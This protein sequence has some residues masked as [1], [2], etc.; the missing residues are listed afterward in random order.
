MRSRAFSRTA[1]RYGIGRFLLKLMLC[2][3]VFLS[4]F[5]LLFGR[6]VRR[7]VVMQGYILAAESLSRSVVTVMEESGLSYS[8][9]CRITYDESGRISSMVYDAVTLNHLISMLELRATESL[10]GKQNT[11]SLPLGTLMGSAL[12]SGRGPSISLHTAALGYVQAESRSDFSS[13]GL[14][15]TRHRIVVTLTAHVNVYVP[16]YAKDFVVTREFF[17]A[18][19]ILVGEVPNMILNG[20]SA[21]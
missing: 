16:F 8:D 18:E 1:K 17:I 9:L 14:N 6:A 5:E 15:Q 2:I 19:T 13:A 20:T 3:F 21:F 10:S 12:L 11:V 7:T 4:L